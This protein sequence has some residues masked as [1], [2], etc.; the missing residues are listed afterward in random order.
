M[1]IVAGDGKKARNFGLPPFGPPPFRRPHPFGAPD[2]FGAP[3]PPFGA[4]TPFGAPPLRGA[5]FRG[6]TFRGPTP[7]GCTSRKRP[8]NGLG[9]KWSGPKVG[10]SWFGPKVVS[11]RGHPLRC[12]LL[13]APLFGAPPWDLLPSAK[14][15]KISPFSLSRLHFRSFFLSLSLQVFS[16]N[17]GGLIESPP[18]CTFGVLGLSC[19]T[20]AAFA[21]CQEFYN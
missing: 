16:W 2:P 12:P 6:A 15:P 17:F 20:P 13:R 9:Q 18:M 8:R 7:W 5:T 14:P 3:T 4:P 19:E 11:A 1:E 10:Q 21:K